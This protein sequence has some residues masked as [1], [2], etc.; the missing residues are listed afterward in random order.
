MASIMHLYS[1]GICIYLYSCGQYHA[2]LAMW[3]VICTCTP[4]AIIMHL[5]SCGQYYAP[6]ASNI[7]LYFCSQYYAPVLLWPVICTSIHVTSIMHL[8]V[9]GQYYSPV[10][11]RP[12]CCSLALGHCLFPQLQ[13]LHKMVITNMSGTIL[14]AE[15]G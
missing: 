4:V 2:S 9:C 11:L 8:Y 10:L 14:A 13:G 1:C 15:R 3:P 7:Q 12:V 5:H 6:V